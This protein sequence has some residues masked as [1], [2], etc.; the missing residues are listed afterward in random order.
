MPALAK[1]LAMRCV[2]NGELTVLLM[3]REKDCFA[4]CMPHEHEPH[5]SIYLSLFGRD[6]P[7]HQTASATVRMQL[8]RAPN[9]EA[10]M[11]A[12]HNFAQSSTQ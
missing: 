10:I 8:M 12:Y 11:Q 3:A 1:P 6:L 5:F 7:A 2:K 4:I 9:D